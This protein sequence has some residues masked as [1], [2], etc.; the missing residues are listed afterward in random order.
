[1]ISNFERCQDMQILKVTALY[2]VWSQEICQD[3]PSCGQDDL[4]LY[5]CSF[6]APGIMFPANIKHKVFWTLKIL[7]FK[8]CSYIP[9]T[10]GISHVFLRIFPD[11]I[12]VFSTPSLHWKKS[13]AQLTIGAVLA[14][15]LRARRYQCSYGVHSFILGYRLQSLAYLINQ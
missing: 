15:S 9:E 7:F 10:W 13:E 11:I 6:S 5:H 14:P 3:A 2:L 1:M 12:D 8:G 4:V